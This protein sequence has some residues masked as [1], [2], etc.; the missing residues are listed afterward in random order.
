MLFSL[1]Q[2]VNEIY[3]FSNLLWLK[4]FELVQDSL[5]YA[6]IYFLFHPFLL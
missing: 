6:L 5:S 4:L 3:H 1:G 2:E